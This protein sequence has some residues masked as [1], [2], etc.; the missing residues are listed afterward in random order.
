[1]EM[2]ARILGR[3][4]SVRFIDGWLRNTHPCFQICGNPP[5]TLSLHSHHTRLS[6]VARLRSG[7]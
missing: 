5:H 7:S 4:V 6:I 1:M 3:F 2:C